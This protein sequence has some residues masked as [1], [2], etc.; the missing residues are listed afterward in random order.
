MVDHDILLAKLECIGFRG[1]TNLFIKNYLTNRNII[2]RIYNTLSSRKIIRYGV[3]QGSVLGPL[4][5]IIFINDISNIFNNEQVNNIN[6][7]L[8]ADDTSITIFAENDTLLTYY[9]QYYMDKLKKWF[10]INKLKLNIEK[11]K[12]LPYINSGILK[13]IIIDNIK[14]D[15]VNNYK[16]LGIYLDSQMTYKKHIHYLSNKLSKIIY[17]IKK[18]SFLD[19]KNLILLYNSFYL[20][21]LSYG[22]D[23]WSNTYKSNITKLIMLQKKV[24]RIIN[25]QIIDKSKLPLIRLTHTGPFF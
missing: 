22:I 3:P 6:I 13:D 7:N 4:L 1:D 14:I 23:V 15:I 12:I 11:T 18:I 21:N 16:F 24:I 10:D 2:T 5:F 25:K 17:T 9:L 20:S 8:Y 19:T